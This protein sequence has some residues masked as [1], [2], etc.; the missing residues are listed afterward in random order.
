MNR[1]TTRTLKRPLTF[2]V[3]ASLALFLLAMALSAHAQVEKPAIKFSMSW[4]YQATQAQFAVAADKGYW[5]SEGM[6]VTLDRGSGSATS[7]QR[8][9]SGAYDFGFADVGTII[10][11][12]AENPQKP[13]MIVF[14]P[15]E[16]FP[17]V[18][19]ALKGKG[20]TKPKDLEGKKVGAP[21]FDGGRQMFPAFAKAN[22]ID[23]SK[24]TWVTM[25]AALREQMLARGE[26]DAITG[27]TTSSIPSLNGLGVKTADLAVL[28]Y[29]DYNLDG[30]G[31]AVIATKDFVEKN[32][33]TVA[34]FVRGVNKGMKD[35]VSDPKGAVAAIKAR[36]PLISTDVEAARLD[37]YIK[38]TVLTANAK[39]NGFGYI[40]KKK[41]DSEI[42]SVLDAFNVKA[43]VKADEVYTD[44]FLPPKA[45]RMP[46]AY[47]D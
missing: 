14:V 22:G 28:K 12:N 29:D 37:M 8:V 40:D 44:K 39:A 47:K 31:N 10:K 42:A 46:P 11:W 34:A 15:E 5:K 3:H 41:M 24:I 35:I 18:A 2:L 7:V 6:E 38:N 9:V 1:S 19:I 17:L 13:L 16:G 36:D 45:D 25:D 32:P 21:T 26:V 23:Q 43:T 27:F 30:F 4:L 33:K 20:I